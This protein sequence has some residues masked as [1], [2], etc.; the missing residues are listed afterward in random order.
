MWTRLKCK[1]ENENHEKK[2]SQWDA[3]GPDGVPMHSPLLRRLSLC[4][5]ITIVPGFHSLCNGADVDPSIRDTSVTWH[6][7]SMVAGSCIHSYGTHFSTWPAVIRLPRQHGP[8]IF[9]S[10]CSVPI[11][12]FSADLMLSIEFSCWEHSVK[13]LLANS[14]HSIQF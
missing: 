1:T 5:S 7:A 4:P 12:L 2:L 11:V 3:L 9:W 8:H 13:H 14:F 6:G 10:S